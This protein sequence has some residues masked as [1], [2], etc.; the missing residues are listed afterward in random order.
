MGSQ[1]VRV[2]DRRFD[3]LAEVVCREEWPRRG[4]P[5]RRSFMLD[6]TDVITMDSLGIAALVAAYR[7]APKGRT[8]SC[9]G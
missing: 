5:A 3:H 8:S 2:H 1:V 9:A 6:F 7:A 4:R